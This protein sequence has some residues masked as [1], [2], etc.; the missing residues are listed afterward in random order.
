MSV[1]GLLD[2][3]KQSGSDGEQIVRDRWVEGKSG[4]NFCTDPRVGVSVCLSVA[5]WLRMDLCISIYRGHMP[6]SSISNH[7]P[8]A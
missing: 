7:E 5:T 3:E 8:K 2:R 6:H 4:E 1:L